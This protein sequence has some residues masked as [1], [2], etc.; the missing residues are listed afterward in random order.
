MGNDGPPPSDAVVLRFWPADAPGFAGCVSLV[1]E[2]DIATH[3][4]VVEAL[5][6]VSGNLLVDLTE[7]TF[8]DSTVIGAVSARSV[9][10]RRDG[11]RL[12]LVVPPA[13]SAVTRVLEIVGMSAIAPMHAG[14]D[15]VPGSQP[16]PDPPA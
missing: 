1:G 4:Q 10:L 15:A 13:G 5:A 3:E 16:R 14:W 2:H 11:H 9:A 7:C 8:I 6:Q 12:E